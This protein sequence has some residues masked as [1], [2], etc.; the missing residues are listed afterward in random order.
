MKT[1]YKYTL[2]LVIS[3]PL[4]FA[5][6]KIEL[7]TADTNVAVVEAYLIPNSDVGIKI[8]KQLIFASED[9]VSQNIAGLNV[10]ISNGL[11]LCKLRLYG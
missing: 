9:T 10:Q 7:Q 8:T 1:I 2:L 6:E 5:C 4:L 3:I 11:E